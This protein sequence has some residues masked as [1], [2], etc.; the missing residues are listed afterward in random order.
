M[1]VKRGK[2]KKKKKI[3]WG[4]GEGGGGGRGSGAHN[5][6]MRSCV[7]DGVQ[8]N[9]PYKFDIKSAAHSNA[10][11]LLAFFFFFFF[12]TCSNLRRVVPLRL[13]T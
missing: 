2:R 1:K 10:K 6:V 3:T 4:L 12:L 5:A 9:S 13:Y 11:R 8:K 7:S